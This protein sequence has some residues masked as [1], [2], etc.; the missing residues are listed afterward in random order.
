MAGVTW[1]NSTWL[2]AETWYQPR[3]FWRENKAYDKMATVRS[4]QPENCEKSSNC[5][6][7]PFTKVLCLVDWKKGLSVDIFCKTRQALSGSYWIDTQHY[8]SSRGV[9]NSQVIYEMFGEFSL[10]NGGEVRRGLIKW[11]YERRDELSEYVNIALCQ[12][13]VSFTEWINI[14][15][16]DKNPV[17]EIA[18]YFLAHMYN[19]HVM[20][21]RT[22]YSWSTLLH[23]FS[24]SD[25]E[26]DEHCDVKLILLGEHRYAHVCPIH[27]PFEIT[28]KPF[29]ESSRIK[30]EDTKEGIKPQVGYSRKA[31][32][33]RKITCRGQQL[34]KKPCSSNISRSN[35]IA[36]NDRA[37]NTRLSNQKRISPKPLHELRQLIMLS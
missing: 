26:I 10:T 24:Y 25:Q 36:D 1:R 16:K 37:H 27:P 15:S 20:I 31:T 32:V 3:Q 7:E 9:I 8:V 6:S 19:K 33:V 2:S 4:A 30:D 29:S 22:S 5:T 13:N 17:D 12:K 11:I 28:P 34:A 35:I 21:Y 23:H 18:I 14:T